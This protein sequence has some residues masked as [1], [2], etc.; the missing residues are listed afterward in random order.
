MPRDITTVL[1]MVWASSPNAEVFNPTDQGV[2]FIVGWNES[3]STRGGDNPE[4]EHFNWFFRLLTSTVRELNKRGMF[5]W[6]DN[7]F[8]SHPA[9]CM[10][11]N[12]SLYA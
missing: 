9:L 10:G 3:F 2:D 7:S 1:E 6:R 5:E 11:S 12:G 4:R 8:Y